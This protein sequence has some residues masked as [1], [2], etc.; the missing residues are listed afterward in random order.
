MCW[1]L[2]FVLHLNDILVAV[3]CKTKIATIL[4]KSCV[5]AMFIFLE[6]KIPI[7]ESCSESESEESS[8]KKPATTT[9]TT[10]KPGV[11]TKPTTTTKKG[12]STTKKLTTKIDSSDYDSSDYSYSDSEETTKKTTAKTTTKGR[13]RIYYLCFPCIKG[14]FLI[15]VIYRYLNKFIITSFCYLCAILY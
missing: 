4:I 12:A 2:T 1:Q 5:D 15:W 14:L 9:K 11:T 8:T 10:L 6:K 7:F 13:Y 3:S